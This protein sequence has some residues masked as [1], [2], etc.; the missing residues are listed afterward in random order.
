MMSE[1]DAAPG[2]A[3]PSDL[4]QSCSQAIVQAVADAEDIHPL[5]IEPPLCKVIDPD[6]LDALFEGGGSA[7]EVEL[8]YDGYQITVR[9][10]SDVTAVPVG[11]SRNG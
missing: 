3:Q 11:E 6:A 4:D 7:S 2:Q 8:I 1:A 10:S 9:G 5:E